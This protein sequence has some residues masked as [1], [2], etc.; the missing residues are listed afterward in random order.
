MTDLEQNLTSRREAGFK[1]SFATLDLGSRYGDR[2]L[3]R[4]DGRRIA[5]MSQQIKVWFD[6][7]GDVL[8]V[9]FSDAPGYLRETEHDAVAIALLSSVTE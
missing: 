8:E 5:I 6:R 3:A 1:K 7:E 2:R 9:L 4:S